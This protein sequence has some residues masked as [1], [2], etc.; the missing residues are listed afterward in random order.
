METKFKIGIGA[1]IILLIAVISA[2]YYFNISAKTPER[3]LRIVEES[4][5]EH[6]KEN[7][8]KYVDVEG[9]LANSYDGIIE[10]MT[11]SNKEMTADAK[12]SVKDF[13]EMLRAPLLLSLQASIDSYVETGDFHDEDNLGVSE[14]L[15]RTGLNKSE[16]RGVGNIKVNPNDDDIAEAD[17]QIYHP[18]IGREFTLK[19]I[20]NRDESGEWKI[21][22]VENFYDFIRQINQTR[23]K[24]LDDYL[25]DSAEINFRHDKTIREAE[26]KYSDTLAA[27][28]LSQES[29][30]KKLQAIMTDEVKKDWEKRK[31]DLL[32]LTVPK[33]AETLQ[34][35]RLKICDLEI[36]Y[37]EGY[38]QWMDDKQ[39]ST[40]KAADEKHRQAQTLKSEEII[41]SRRMAE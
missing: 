34:N 16:F 1:G 22:R 19:F 20:L 2:W 31:S 39:A 30:R 38:A 15:K 28:S 8:Y 10:G 14:L 12:E 9:I 4:I 33:D 23:R 36:A 32:S 29:T 7:F 41:L 3:A 27:G 21:V 11:Y 18:E 13:T 40:V 24:K 26:K 37:S 35:L 25:K 17:I 5:H 6:N